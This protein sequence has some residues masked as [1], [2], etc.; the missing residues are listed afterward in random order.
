MAGYIPS[1]EQ[2]TDVVTDR[3]RDWSPK[4]EQALRVQGIRD[5]KVDVLLRVEAICMQR[6]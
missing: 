4:I 1:E 6:S 5:R 3:E 2:V